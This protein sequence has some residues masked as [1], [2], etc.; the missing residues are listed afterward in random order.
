MQS[1]TQSELEGIW[2]VQ[3]VL[4]LGTAMTWNG[5]T[6]NFGLPEMK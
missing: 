5:H 1:L 3:Q 2:Y 4:Q 6:Q